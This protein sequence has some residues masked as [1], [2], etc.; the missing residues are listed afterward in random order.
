MPWP[1]IHVPQ[2]CLYH[3]YHDGPRL[4]YFLC[5]QYSLFQG[6]AIPGFNHKDPTDRFI[7]G[8]HCKCNCCFMKKND[9]V[10]I[11]M[12]YIIIF[13]YIST[14]EAI[15]YIQHKIS[16]IYVEKWI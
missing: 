16:M 11:H 4:V 8:V 5:I 15:V 6:F 3:S 1:I 10:K 2:I 7:K 13:S 9:I 14:T 12:N